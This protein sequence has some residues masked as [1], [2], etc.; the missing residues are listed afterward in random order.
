MLVANLKLQIKAWYEKIRNLTN[1]VLLG[2]SFLII[3]LVLGDVF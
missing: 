2:F 1:L 3:M